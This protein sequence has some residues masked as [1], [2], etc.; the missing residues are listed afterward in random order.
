MYHRRYSLVRRSVRSCYEGFVSRVGNAATQ[1]I[2]CNL[3]FSAPTLGRLA[4]SSSHPQHQQQLDALH[5]QTTSHSARIVS[6][7]FCTNRS[8][9]SRGCDSIISS[10]YFV[11][12]AGQ[13]SPLFGLGTLGIVEEERLSIVKQGSHL[14]HN[15]L[16]LLL[17][18][19]GLFKCHWI[20]F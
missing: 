14:G 16:I 10:K 13:Y 4:S 15:I 3:T 12:L 19:L 6:L 18:L 17:R 11:W 7:G 2:T 5:F 9:A 8:M 1:P 20:S